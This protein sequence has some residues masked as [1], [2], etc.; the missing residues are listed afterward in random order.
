MEYDKKILQKIVNQCRENTFEVLEAGKIGHVGGSLSVIEILVALYFQ[1][2]RTDPKN[3]KWVDRDRIVLSKAHA[4]EA[5]YGVLGEKGFFSKEK[6]KEFLKFNS[7]LQGH[8]EICTPG[9][10]YSGGSL[11]QGISFACGIAYSAI[12][13]KKDFRVYCI[14]GDGEC[15][16]GEVWEAAMFASHYKLDNLYVVVDYN[17]YCTVGN[18]D[19]LMNLQPFENKWKSF[20]WETMFEENGNDVISLVKDFENL[21]K[22]KGKPKCIIAN[23][24]KGCGVP[25]WE[26]KHAHH[27]ADDALMD[28]IKEGRR[29]LKDES[30]S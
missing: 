10:E 19:E 28:G 27:L 20:G 12:L 21:E 30:N 22:A 6:F 1:I 26:K 5:M 8:A 13:R 24:K 15:H 18:V 29:F 7:I 25:S 14:L 9:I 3:P 23:T 4:C 2:A 17:H 11:G 16:E